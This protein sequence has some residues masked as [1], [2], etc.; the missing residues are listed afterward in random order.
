MRLVCLVSLLATTSATKD[1]KIRTRA[2]DYG[3]IPTTGAYPLLPICVFSPA[4]IQSSVDYVPPGGFPDTTWSDPSNWGETILQWLQT[5]DF[6]ASAVEIDVTENSLPA[7]DDSID[8]S[9]AIAAILDTVSISSRRVLVF[10]AGI[11]YFNSTLKIVRLMLPN[12]RTN[13]TSS[14]A[15]VQCYPSRRLP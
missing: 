13:L 7:D 15:I 5:E 2:I 1:T 3:S 11:Y 4:H 14:S 8:A 6:I 12:N 10:P 9:V